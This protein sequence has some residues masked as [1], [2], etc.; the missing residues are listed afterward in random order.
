MNSETVNGADDN[1]V[2]A[3]RDMTDGRVADVCTDAVGMEADHTLLDKMSNVLHGEAGSIKALRQCLSAVRRGGVVSVVGA[4]GMPYDN[5]PLGQTF[6]K[7]ITMC[8]GQ[9]P[10]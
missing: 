7:A 10:V 9:A 6:D 5:F 1:P 8:F 4:Y 2:G 3:I